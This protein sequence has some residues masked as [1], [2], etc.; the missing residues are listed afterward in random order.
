MEIREKI[1][2]RA[3]EISLVGL[4]VGVPVVTFAIDVYLTNQRYN[5]LS[6]QEKIGYN[7]RIINN[8]PEAGFRPSL[9]ALSGQKKRQA[10]MRL[11]ELKDSTNYK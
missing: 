8:Y 1:R 2:K 9:L 7:Q 4:M 6:R 3:L 11:A 10:E 5:S